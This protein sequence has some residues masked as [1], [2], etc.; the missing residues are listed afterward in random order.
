MV[1]HNAKHNRKQLC[2]LQHLRTAP[3]GRHRETAAAGTSMGWSAIPTP[4]SLT[5]QTE[6]LVKRTHRLMWN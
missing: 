2:T 1:F 4:M 6:P 5:E 3:L